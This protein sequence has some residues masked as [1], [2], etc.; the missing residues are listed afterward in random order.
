MNPHPIPPITIDDLNAQ[1][2]TSG[3]F[4]LSGLEQA[5]NADYSNLKISAYDPSSNTMSVVGGGTSS[6]TGATIPSIMSSS[7]SVQWTTNNTSGP[8]N[9]GG[10][11]TVSDWTI[12]PTPAGLTAG[13][14]ALTGENADITINGQSLLT[15]IRGIEA[16]LGLL[17]PTPA[18]EQEW[19]ELKE[20]GDRYRAL[21]KHIQEKQATWDRLKAMPPPM[22]D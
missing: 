10:V 6:V 2:T 22:V 5:Y 21:E 17:K 11:G 3:V 1:V 16:R 8:W 13:Q 14:L 18:L 20:L 12:R 4:G 9:L 15:M 7:G 19:E